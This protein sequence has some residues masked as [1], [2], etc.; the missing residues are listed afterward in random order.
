M[1]AI[2]RKSPSNKVVV[3][4]DDET[5]HY[6]YQ[7]FTKRTIRLTS[8]FPSG[9]MPLIGSS[10]TKSNHASSIDFQCDASVPELLLLAQNGSP[11]LCSISA[12]SFL[13]GMP[14]FSSDL[15]LIIVPSWLITSHR[16]NHYIHIFS[17]GKTWS[18]HELRYVMP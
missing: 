6:V 3:D 10:P 18:H 12:Y 2:C 17:C 5:N 11:A 7:L 14:V 13:P 9:R 1:A 16:L 4:T 8:I 15:S